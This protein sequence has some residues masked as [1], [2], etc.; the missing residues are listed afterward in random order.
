MLQAFLFLAR[1]QAYPMERGMEYSMKANASLEKAV[2]LNPENPR[3]YY[4]RGTTL[5]FTPE[6]YGGGK[7]AA[8]P[9][10]MQAKEKFAQFVPPSEF[11]PRWGKAH[12]EM[13]I[14]GRAQ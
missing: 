9:L 2:S 11:W 8:M 14:N 7:E 1:I 12:L 13:L 6:Q 3:S 5:Y 4:L 10:L